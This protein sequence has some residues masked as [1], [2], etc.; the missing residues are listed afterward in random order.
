MSARQN[1]TNMNTSLTFIT[2]P[3]RPSQFS[4][5]AFFPQ[6]HLLEEYWMLELSIVNLLKREL[7][8]NEKCET[9]RCTF[10]CCRD[11]TMSL[12]MCH[13]SISLNQER[14]QARMLSFRAVVAPDFFATRHFD[15][16]DRKISVKIHYYPSTCTQL[17]RG[18]GRGG[19]E[20]ARSWTVNGCRVMRAH[21]TSPS[22]YFR[23]SVRQSRFG[24][25]I[26]SFWHA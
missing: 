22:K 1:P 5:W 13:L 9:R 20:R 18:R 25:D 14:L 8:G 4:L 19:E 26:I 11:K 12:R 21:S 16:Q 17:C 6:R 7:K 3:L 23:W 2:P 24:N 15:R 10:V